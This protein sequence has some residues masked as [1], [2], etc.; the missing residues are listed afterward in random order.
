MKD[1]T[2][3]RLLT[4][5]L[6]VLVVGVAVQ[7]N[8]LAELQD[9][10]SALELV[11]APS[12]GRTAVAKVDAAQ[13]AVGGASVGTPGQSG[14]GPTHGLVPLARV[15]DRMRS[16]FDEFFGPAAPGA[17][18][19]VGGSAAF[20]SLFD[21]PSAGDWLAAGFGGL[22]GAT[23]SLDLRDLGDRYRLE[24]DLPGTDEAEIDVR[25]EGGMLVVEG[26]RESLSETD[27]PDEYVRRERSFGRFERRLV[28][29]ADADPAS[30]ELEY[31]NGVL[32]VTIDKRGTGSNAAAPAT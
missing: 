5:L 15:E 11:A 20:R 4:A 25:T 22:L 29:P 2:T 19:P 6:A 1:R 9:K 24:I 17:F 16:L 18:Q 13:P 23:P 30:I 8:F 28:L 10:V 32:S 3:V 27:G 21:R 14:S 12:D 7:A 26:T 31:S